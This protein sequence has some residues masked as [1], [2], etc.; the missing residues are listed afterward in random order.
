MVKAD[1]FLSTLICKSIKM[2]PGLKNENPDHSVFHTVFT[3]LFQIRADIPLSLE[4]SSRALTHHEY[5]KASQSI[6]G[7]F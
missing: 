5:R 7:Y 6:S 3:Y 1:F 4:S 2:I